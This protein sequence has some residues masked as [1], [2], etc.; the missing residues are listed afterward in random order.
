MTL[1]IYKNVL[2]ILQELVVIFQVF[3]QWLAK[4]PY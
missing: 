2:L 3:K 4:P 1:F